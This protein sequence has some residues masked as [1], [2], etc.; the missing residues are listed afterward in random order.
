MNY[1]KESKFLKTLSS[2]RAELQP[3]FKLPPISPPVCH[4]PPSPPTTS[5]QSQPFPAVLHPPEYPLDDSVYSI[6]SFLAQLSLAHHGEFI[7]RGSLIC[8]LHSLSTKKIRRFLYAH[9]TDATYLT[10]EAAERGLLGSRAQEFND[11]LNHI[12]PEAQ[13]KQ[14]VE[15]FFQD[16][17]WRFGIPEKWFMRTCRQMW[18][19]MRRR[20][21]HHRGSQ[22]NPN[23]VCL[24]FSILA[25]SPWSS[26]KDDS[27][28]DAD[29]ETFDT[30]F[31]CAMAARCIA[32]TL[33]LEEPN[34]SIMVSA[35]DGTVLSC[36]AV[37]L[38]CNYLAERGHASEAWKL[39]GK[40]ISSATAVGMHQDP[41]WPYWQVMSEEEKLLRRRAWWG[42]FVWDRL[43]SY[44]LGRPQFL[45]KDFSD[46]EYPVDESL[47]SQD[48]LSIGQIALI[49][50]ADI[51]GEAIDKTFV[52]EYP[53]CPIFFDLDEKFEKWEENLLPEY[54]RID[55]DDSAC[56]QRESPESLLVAR[57]SY[58]L[59][60]WYLLS[61]VKLHIACTT[62]Q[63]RVAKP[64]NL[65]VESRERC[66][67]AAT[68]LIRL[69][70]DVL[71]LTVGT[72]TGDGVRRPFNA[73]SSWYFEA[74]FSLLE[75]SV[76]VMTI[77]AHRPFPEEAK[78]I[79]ALL[80]RSLDVFKRV[81]AHERGKR[82]TIA[83]MSVEVL[84]VLQ[85]QNVPP[86]LHH[87]FGIEET[88]V[89]SPHTLPD[90]PLVDTSDTKDGVQVFGMHP[91][92]SPC[93]VF[94]PSQ[95]IRSDDVISHAMECD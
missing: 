80:D 15:A 66:L 31:K 45:R 62:G 34:S 23:W 86:E 14:L 94:S 18:N 72:Q 27:M 28:E 38:L 1:D 89:P 13:A 56:N 57:L 77:M 22:L 29:Y 58:L 7:G 84:G 95:A 88:K 17:N 75:A 85:D 37:P 9:S 91:S 82:G 59:K 42:L 87:G 46:V 43:Y 33:Y 64:L 69:Q 11:L 6:T 51:V 48:I 93:S 54:K 5:Q 32:E 52:V 3:K 24:F 70:C 49:Q 67:A 36:L 92:M 26:I 35:A 2:N 61:R 78:E 73:G 44:V 4:R 81:A 8:A 68:Q 39:V 79:D 12:P 76:T 40:A 50:L 41:G 74:C 20:S 60:T 30:Y 63:G 21:Q 71:D 16:V 25:V 55:M 47:G 53:D 19:I 83:R 65:A 10:Q 90:V